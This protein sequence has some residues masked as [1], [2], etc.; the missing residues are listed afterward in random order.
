MEPKRGRRAAPS[1]DFDLV[2]AKPTEAESLERS[3]L[4]REAGGKVTSGASAESAELALTD[5]EDALSERWPA[6][7]GLFD[8]LDLDQ[9]DPGARRRQ[10]ARRRT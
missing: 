6:R 8:P 7:Q 4:G 10:S 1:F 2:K 3:L 5:G 9:V